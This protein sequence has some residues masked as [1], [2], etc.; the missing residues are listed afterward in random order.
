M[1]DK[2]LKFGKIAVATVMICSGIGTSWLN[3]QPAMAHHSYSTNYD[4]NNPR[5]V[6]GVIQSV[7]YGSPHVQ[8]TLQ[9]ADSQTWTIEM[10]SPPRA[11]Q[12]GLTESFLRVGSTA[13]VVGY[14]ARDGS[15]EIGATQITIEDAA[16]QVR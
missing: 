11:Q 13:T 7:R 1:S 4:S 6:T 9:G 5:T 14:P 12:R 8:M 16:I 3:A 15:Y 10:P 2:M